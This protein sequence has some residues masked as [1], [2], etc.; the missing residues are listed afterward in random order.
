MENG[1][2]RYS[3]VKPKRDRWKYTHTGWCTYFREF[4]YRSFIH[5][6]LSLR[7]IV[8]TQWRTSVHTHI[9]TMDSPDLRRLARINFMWLLRFQ[10]LFHVTSYSFT[11]IF[12]CTISA[13]YYA[14]SKILK[15][16]IKLLPDYYLFPECNWFRK[17]MTP[18]MK[19]LFYRVVTNFLI[20]ASSSKILFIIVSS[21]LFGHKILG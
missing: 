10:H 20:L 4:S 14:V 16:Y 17:I 13:R 19:V 3:K 6:R 9:S 7:V 15:T 5:T 11:R 1:W 21:F 2:K 18:M 12:V 8:A